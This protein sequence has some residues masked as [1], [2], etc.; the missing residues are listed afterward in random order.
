MLARH[1]RG[2]ADLD[3]R[4]ADLAKHADA[5]DRSEAEGAS[6]LKDAK[7]ALQRLEN[8]FGLGGK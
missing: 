4:H 7:A 1:L 2:A 5:L 6:L 3:R 8:A